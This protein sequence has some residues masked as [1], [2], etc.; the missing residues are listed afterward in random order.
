MRVSIRQMIGPHLLE[1]FQVGHPDD[2]GDTGE[3]FPYRAWKWLLQHKPRIGGRADLFDRLE[4]IDWDVLVLLDA[5][6]YD[7][8][9][10]VADTAVVDCVQSPA[11]ATPEFLTKAGRREVFADSVYVSGNPQ[12]DDAYLGENVRHIPVYADQWDDALSTVRPED[13]YG[14]AADEVG[15]GRPVVAHTLQPHYPHV[16]EIDGRTVPV[17]NGVHPASYGGEKLSSG[18]FQAALASGCV[19]LETMRKSYVV[20]T[21]YAWRRAS[22]FAVGMA[23]EGYR[24]VISADHGELF[25]EY[26]LV[27]HPV[28]VRLPKVERVPWVVFEPGTDATTEDDVTGRLEALGYV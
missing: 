11:S 5:C 3:P 23:E 18:G 10:A 7:T 6:R 15:D 14:A 16:C 28:D 8:L 1:A 2:C 27:E 25:G 19:D 26:G 12:T 4:S 20:A 9:D 21:R 22:S 13:I 17:P 24:V